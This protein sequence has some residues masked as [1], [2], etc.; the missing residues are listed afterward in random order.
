MRV[1]GREGMDFIGVE[2]GAQQS[3]SR[4][5]AGRPMLP[6]ILELRVWG[7]VAG[8]G[9]HRGMRGD[10]VQTVVAALELPSSEALFNFTLPRTPWT[11]CAGGHCTGPAA[12]A[13]QPHP[14]QSVRHLEIKVGSMR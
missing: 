14:L 2:G 10:G 13:A 12:A 9:V 11:R 6:G 4:L 8:R 1:W 7:R 5:S 3:K